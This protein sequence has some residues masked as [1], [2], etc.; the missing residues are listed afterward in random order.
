[1][2]RTESNRPDKRFTLGLLAMDGCMLSSLTGPMDVLRVAQKLA[3]VRDPNTP[4][5]LQT[6]LVGAR[7]QA[8]HETLGEQLPHEPRT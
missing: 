2:S 1:M 7:G 8:E 3:E 6:V 5:R 4:L